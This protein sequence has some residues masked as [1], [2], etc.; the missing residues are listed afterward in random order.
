LMENLS[1]YEATYGEITIPGNTSL[2]DH[3]FRPPT[4]PDE[5]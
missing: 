5:S 3:L 2:A 1:K 4:P